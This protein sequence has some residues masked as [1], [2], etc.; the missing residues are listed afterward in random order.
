MGLVTLMLAWSIVGTDFSTWR[1]LGGL[2]GV[3]CV[4]IVAIA[5]FIF[6]E[7]RPAL[8]Q[9]SPAN[10]PFAGI[11]VLKIVAPLSILVMLFLTWLTL[12]DPGLALTGKPDNFWQ[13]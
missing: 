13:V 12:A 1:A 6:P 8:Y 3:E 11:P 9:A 7:R 10:V 5:A 4:G 2:A